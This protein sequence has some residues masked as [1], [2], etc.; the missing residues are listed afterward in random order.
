MIYGSIPKKGI[1]FGNLFTVRFG[2]DSLL[3][4][5]VRQGPADKRRE[6]VPVVI[7]AVFRTNMESARVFCYAI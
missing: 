4:A 5:N 1:L 7:G 6:I 3:E 2:R